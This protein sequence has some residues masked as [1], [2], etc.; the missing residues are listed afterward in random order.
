MALRCT[1]P[2][3][4]VWRSSDSIVAISREGA[5]VKK[6][7]VFGPSD[8]SIGSYSEGRSWVKGS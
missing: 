6:L 1:V 8:L 3:D 2:G 5:S 7:S 4:S